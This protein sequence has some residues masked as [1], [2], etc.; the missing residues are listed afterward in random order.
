MKRSS[1]LFKAQAVGSGVSPFSSFFS[2]EL[3]KGFIEEFKLMRRT[4][5]ALE[6]LMSSL[7]VHKSEGGA[8]RQDED[9]NVN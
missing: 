3:Q 9:K 5:R 8:R 6:C 2:Q 7:S 1:N 4:K